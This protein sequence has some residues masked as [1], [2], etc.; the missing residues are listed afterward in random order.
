MNS[1]LALTLL[2]LIVP[3]RPLPVFQDTEEVQSETTSFMCPPCGPDCH[4][5]RYQAAGN[6]STCGMQLVPVSDVPHVAVLLYP[7]CDLL[8]WSSAATVLRT[9][10]KFHVFTVADSVDPLRCGNLVEIT[11]DHSFDNAPQADVIVVAG[12]RGMVDIA[13][14]QLY[15]DWLRAAGAGAKRV[16][17]LDTGTYLMGA[18]GLLEGKPATTAPSSQR[19]WS[20]IAESLDLHTDERIVQAE[21]VLT[22]RDAGAATEAALLIVRELAGDQAAQR[23]IER[24]GLEIAVESR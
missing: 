1:T 19:R 8:A 13:S 4:R 22:T 15:I 2:A 10:G 6:C 18:A 9:A 16:L 7:D 21:G 24:L 23:V 5:E 20:E 11:S 14:D 17:G 3:F 12:G